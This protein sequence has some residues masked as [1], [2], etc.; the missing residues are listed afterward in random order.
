M[1]TH[2]K[3]SDWFF[4]AETSLED[5]LEGSSASSVFILS[6]HINSI[7]CIYIQLWDQFII[8]CEINSQSFL[9]VSS[10][11]RHFP[12]RSSVWTENTHLRLVLPLVM[13]TQVDQYRYSYKNVSVSFTFLF[14][15]LVCPISQITSY[16]HSDTFCRS[17]QKTIQIHSAFRKHCFQPNWNW[18]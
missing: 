18:R 3:S 6:I 7:I 5:S 8:H 15:V 10:I 1:F 9:S 11:H 13:T 16:E 2:T 17:S 12:R 4:V 14:Y